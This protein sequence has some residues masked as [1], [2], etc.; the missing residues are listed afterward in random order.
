MIDKRVFAGL[1]TIFIL[2]LL[3][4]V[5]LV[6]GKSDVKKTDLSL[7][8]I[9]PTDFLLEKR[10]VT[11]DGN[12]DLKIVLT[13]LFNGSD[14]TN[15]EN[16]FPKDVTFISSKVDKENDMIIVDLS[17]NILSINYG[18]KVNYLYIMSIVHT[19][20]EFTGYDKVK[21]TFDG[22]TVQFF[23]NGLYIGDA[24]KRDYTVVKL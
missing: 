22:K 14:D 11:V 6:F 1:G 16:L 19:V 7:Y 20:G 3:L 21:L 15:L 2:L 18:L 9:N 10:I 5:I 17:S 12:A 23:D 4:A 8:Y 13:N 24:L